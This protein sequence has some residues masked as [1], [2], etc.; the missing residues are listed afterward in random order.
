MDMLETIRNGSPSE[1]KTSNKHSKVLMLP[2]KSMSMEDFKERE[3]R[4]RKM[5][6]QR[7]QTVYTKKQPQKP[8]LL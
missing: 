6:S 5:R 4:K 3:K 7:K 8:S 1:G 2:G